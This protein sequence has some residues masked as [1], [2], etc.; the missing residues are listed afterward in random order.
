MSLATNIRTEVGL[1]AKSSPQ[2]EKTQSAQWSD[3]S[4]TMKYI[5]NQLGN[6]HLVGHRGGGDTAFSGRLMW[7]QAIVPFRELF[8]LIL[9]N[10]DT[11]NSYG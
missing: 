5:N 1:N 6:F 9:V 10:L 7:R 2:S 11:L 3:R 8:H 4:P